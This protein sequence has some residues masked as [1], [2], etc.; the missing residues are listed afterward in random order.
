[1]VVER[2]QDQA[3]DG[4]ADWGQAT[5]LSNDDTMSLSSAQR[6]IYAIE[7]FEA[8]PREHIRPHELLNYFSFETAP[9]APENDFSV[10]GS[11]LPKLGK[12][13]SYSLALAVAGR[14]IDT[15]AR[16]NVALTVVLDRSGSMSDEGRMDYLKRGMVR[17]VRELKRG[18]L[19]NLVL[20]D[21]ELCVPVENFVVGR[22][23]ESILTGLID[24][25]APRGS[26]DL[27]LGLTKGYELAD[28]GYRPEYSNRVLLVTDALTNTGVTDEKL[29]AT[30]SKHYDARRIRLS[31]IGVGR[32]FNDSLLD[33]LT[34]RGRG[35]YV[36]LGSPA[37]VDA[38]FG[39]RFVSLVETTALDVHFRLH[40]P[41]SLRL[42]TFYG[43]EAS[44]VKE[45]V[46]A[47]HYFANTSQLFLQDVMAKGQRLRPQDD[48]M[49]SIQY[50]DPESGQARVEE[51]PLRLGE[52]PMNG[53]NARKGVLLMRFID[54]LAWLAERSQAGR[55]GTVEDASSVRECAEGRAA[56]AELAQPLAGDAEVARVL[57]LWQ[58]Y[59]S[60]FR[61]AEPP[62]P[63]PREPRQSWPG[64][65]G[66]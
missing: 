11:L 29:I 24:R 13:G 48:V 37:E 60:R 18:D 40:L 8:L 30:V 42:D 55:A 4:Y 12:A 19:L 61:A 59:C 64:A 41:P 22:D 44:T 34:E 28:R 51:F 50:T 21:D 23:S 45:D 38:V 35:A 56:L 49:L 16:R 58:T 17:M 31:G 54:G 20:F 62:R 65:Q 57:E 33:R 3:D 66:R 1:V 6:V 43:E 36:F 10:T 47:I 63:G 46:Q 52:L 26:T 14:P 27:H 7:H 53:R 32:E 25:L 2:P 9:L 15:A 5:Y 39:E